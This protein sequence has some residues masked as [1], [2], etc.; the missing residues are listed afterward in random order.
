MIRVG[1]DD[2]L[3]RVARRDTG[4]LLVGTTP[5][6]TSSTPEERQRIAALTLERLHE[7]DPDASVLYD[8]A[9]E[10]DPNADEAPFPYLPTVDSDGFPTDHLSRRTNPALVHRCAGTDTREQLGP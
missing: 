1:P 3:P 2:L 7:A 9:E 8:I 4:I 6:R 10:V 5:P